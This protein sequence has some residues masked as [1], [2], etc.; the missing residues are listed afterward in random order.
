MI[1]PCQISSSV[2]LHLKRAHYAP[3]LQNG[4]KLCCL[5]ITVWNSKMSPNGIKEPK[6]K[7]QSSLKQFS[8]F[9]STI[10]SLA[11]DMIDNSR[12]FS[13]TSGWLFLSLCLSRLTSSWHGHRRQLPWPPFPK[14]TDA[15]RH[16]VSRLTQ[17]DE[18]PLI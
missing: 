5:T 16:A 2:I 15:L 8:H 9:V 17:R 12:A 13:V 11:R 7:D 6:P 18:W 3:W 14:A 1:R 10:I 4:L